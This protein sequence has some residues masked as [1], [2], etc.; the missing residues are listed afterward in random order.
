MK[1][2]LIVAICVIVLFSLMSCGNNDDTSI[3]CTSCGESI[4]V[5]AKFCSHCG[6]TVLDSSEGDNN[7]DKISVYTIGNQQPALNQRFAMNV[8]KL[9]AAR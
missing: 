1:K 9:V 4:A 6:E 8:V 3:K 2:S 7:D 5:D